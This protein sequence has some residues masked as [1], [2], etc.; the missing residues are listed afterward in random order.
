MKAAHRLVSLLD[1]DDTLYNNDQAEADLKRHLQHMFGAAAR[2]RYWAIYE[3]LRAEEGYADYL[4]AL[5]RFRLEM[6]HDPRVLSLSAYL[7]AYPSRRC[8][9]PG[10]LAAIRH[11]QRWGMAV[12]LSDGDAV[13]QP[14]KVMQSGLQDAVHG[15][16]LIFVHKEQ[17]LA[18]VE[19]TYP[20][21]HY[22]LVD[23]KLRILAAIKHVWGQRVTTV[24]PRQGHYARDP[25]AAAGYPPADVT[26]DRIGDLASYDLHTLLTAAK[27]MFTNA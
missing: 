19:R 15:H 17:Q 4:G 8:L 7:L 16:T 24:H 13:Y 5:E 12:I 11:L 23:D 10:A 21:E 25:R 2:D 22:I 6:L 9:Y 26:I 18:D 20:A 1:V 3:Q 14:H 27:G